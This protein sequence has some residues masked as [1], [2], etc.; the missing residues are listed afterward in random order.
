MQEGEKR[1]RPLV[2]FTFIYLYKLEEPLLG[3]DR[4]IEEDGKR[5]K[6]LAGFSGG[7]TRDGIMAIFKC[8]RIV[9]LG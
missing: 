3:S 5:A 9:V 6:R 2:K 7:Y 8:L 1:G 4:F